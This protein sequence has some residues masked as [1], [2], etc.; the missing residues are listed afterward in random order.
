MKE[1]A[2]VA[3]RRQRNK[4]ATAGGTEQLSVVRQRQTKH[5][6]PPMH[7]CHLLQKS[8][9]ALHRLHYLQLALSGP[10]YRF[11]PSCS[12][13]PISRVWNASST[14]FMLAIFSCA[15]WLALIPCDVAR[16]KSFKLVPA[17]AATIWL[18]V[19][20]A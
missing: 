7:A 10:H 2:R 19:L 5:R 12:N 14:A 18:L 16:Y 6:P 4:L 20:T 13:G 3:Q 1:W 11:A 8:G 9:H 17:A 15:C